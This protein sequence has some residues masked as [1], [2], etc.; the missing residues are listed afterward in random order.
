MQK[1]FIIKRLFSKKNQVKFKS[2]TCYYSKTTTYHKIFWK[3]W[4][5]FFLEVGLSQRRKN[6]AKWLS[7]NIE[8]LC[9]SLIIIFWNKYG[10]LLYLYIFEEITLLNDIQLVECR[11][12]VFWF[13]A[14]YPSHFVF[15]TISLS[16]FV[17]TINISTEKNM[18]FVLH[19]RHELPGCN[20][21]LCV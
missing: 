15:R 20:K 21:M 16:Y 13:K 11:K 10:E 9:D 18:N 8:I 17:Y 1:S 5:R 6:N 2:S 19:S 14:F 3:S 12:Q 4:R 7:V